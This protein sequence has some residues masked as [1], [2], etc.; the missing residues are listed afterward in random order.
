MRAKL[1]RLCR[2][3]LEPTLRAITGTHKQTRSP[4]GF[5][6]TIKTTSTTPLARALGLAAETEEVVLVVFNSR[7]T[8]HLTK[9]AH[10]NATLEKISRRPVELVLVRCA[11][12]SRA[13]TWRR[14]R[15][16]RRVRRRKCGTGQHQPADV[17]PQRPGG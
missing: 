1:C 4:L 11:G 10:E 3:R 5:N 15:R 14:W 13:A 9:Y 16:V 8:G 7:S 2:I 12:S 6:R 17:H